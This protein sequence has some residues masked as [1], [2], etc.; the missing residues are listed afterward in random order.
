M[1]VQQRKHNWK[2]QGYYLYGCCH[3]YC[4]F[5]KIQKHLP[6]ISK[7]NE[8][9]RKWNAYVKRFLKMLNSSIIWAHQNAP[10]VQTYYAMFCLNYSLYLLTSV[11]G[12]SS[13]WSSSESSDITIL[14]SSFL[15]LFF[16]F[17]F[18]LSF[19]LFEGC[20]FLLKWDH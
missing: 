8:F 20:C 11:S 9:T 14:S 19:S 4:D 15:F 1:P 13:S 7:T 5:L 2:I 18:G 17:L 16:L 3:G 12:S 10:K 6:K